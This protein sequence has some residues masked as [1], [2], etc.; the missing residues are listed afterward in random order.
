MPS[1][2]SDTQLSCCTMSEKPLQVDWFTSTTLQASSTRP[3]F[4]VYRYTR[5]TGNSHQCTRTLATVISVPV[6]WQQ[7]SVYRYTDD[8]HQ[9]TGTL[10]TFTSVL[11]ITSDKDPFQDCDFFKNLIN[12]VKIFF[13]ENI[14]KCSIKSLIFHTPHSW[15][16][17]VAR[18]S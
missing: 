6:H 17:Y 2:T 13:P 3:T 11:T 15:F 1:F 18:R 9:C 8:S 7:S 12:L 16:H 5:Y 4:L 14:N 10:M